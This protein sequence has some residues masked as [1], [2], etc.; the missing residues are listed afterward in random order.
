MGNASENVKLNAMEI[1]DHVENDGVKL[2]LEK[3]VFERI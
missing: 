3:H 2:A 1:T